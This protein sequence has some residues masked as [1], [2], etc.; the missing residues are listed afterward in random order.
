[1]SGHQR[2]LFRPGAKF[3]FAIVVVFR[4]GELRGPSS[5][6]R[7]QG[8]EAF[9]DL[10]LPLALLR[11]WYFSFVHGAGTIGSGESNARVIVCPFRPDVRNSA[12][13]WPVL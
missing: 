5:L 7:P 9:F 3:V 2:P 6:S 4:Q 11:S 1:M 13:V 8:S 12:Y 10:T